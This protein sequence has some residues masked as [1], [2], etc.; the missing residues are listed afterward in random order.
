MKRAVL[1]EEAERAQRVGVR[2]SEEQVAEA[3]RHHERG[4]DWSTA[5]LA[6]NSDQL[7]SDGDGK[8]VE[9]D[10]GDQYQLYSTSQLTWLKNLASRMDRFI[11]K[12]EIPLGR[13][14]QDCSDW[15]RE[16]FR[17]RSA[18]RSTGIRSSTWSPPHHSEA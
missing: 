2:V 14:R 6:W 12:I 13:C 11:K 17:T 4:R 10:L 7:D 5:P 8:G 16:D 9:C 1:K 15:L 3:L 18:S